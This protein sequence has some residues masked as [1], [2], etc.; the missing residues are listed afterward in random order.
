[1]NRRASEIVMSARP[2]CRAEQNFTGERTI[3]APGV[4]QL[5]GPHQWS[6]P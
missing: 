4:P 6:Y 3:A 1:M 5:S 2:V